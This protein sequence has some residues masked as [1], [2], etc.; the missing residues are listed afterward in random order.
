ML[1]VSLQPHHE[2]AQRV[3]AATGEYARA[4]H[5]WHTACS[6]TRRVLNDASKLQEAN[7]ASAIVPKHR[8][9]GVSVTGAGHGL[10][11]AIKKHGVALQS[12][13]VCC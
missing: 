6:I 9:A 12:R 3:V 2:V 13:G 5:I 8:N 10:Y 1:Q 7:D 4:R 11:I